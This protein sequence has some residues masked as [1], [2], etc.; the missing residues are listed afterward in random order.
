M[1]YCSNPK[2]DHSSFKYHTLIQC[3]SMFEHIQCFFHPSLAFLQ[4][5]TFSST[6]M[7]LYI[8]RCLRRLVRCYSAFEHSQGFSSP[9][10]FIL[11]SMISDKIQELTYFFSNFY[12]QYLKYSIHMLKYIRPQ[13]QWILLLLIRWP[14]LTDFVPQDTEDF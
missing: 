9:L 14:F 13:I 7:R 1:I 3:Y 6:S 4:L 8:S 2:L 11:Y 12:M 10:F 5:V